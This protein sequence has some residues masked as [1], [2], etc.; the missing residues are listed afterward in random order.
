MPHKTSILVGISVTMDITTKLRQ[1]SYSR[2]GDY[3]AC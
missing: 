3:N 1:P 2:N